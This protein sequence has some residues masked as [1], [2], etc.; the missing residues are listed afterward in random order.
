MSSIAVSRVPFDR[1]LRPRLF[2]VDETESIVVEIIST[3]VVNAIV[4]D[5]ITVEFSLI[6][7]SSSHSGFITN[8]IFPLFLSKLRRLFTDGATV[9]AETETNAKI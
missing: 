1:D 6:F 5:G 2:I 9:E 7:R 3:A 8:G 4:L